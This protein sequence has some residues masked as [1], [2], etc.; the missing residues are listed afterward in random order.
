MTDTVDN[1]PVEP[2][3][4]PTPNNL[5]EA[6]GVAQSATPE[7]FDFVLDKYRKEGRSEQEA[8]LEQAKAYVEAQKRLGGFTGAPESY[9]VKL[10]EALAEMGV[11]IEA[12]DPLVQDAIEFAK[13]N[14]MNQE[15]FSGMLELYAKAEVAKQ[16]AEREYVDNAIKQM[17]HDGMERI[18]SLYQWGQANLDAEALEGFK[19]MAVSPEAIKAMEAMVNKTRNA[20][21]NP[22]AI[23]ASPATMTKAEWEKL[24]FEKDQYGNRRVATDPDFRRKVDDIGK[25]LFGAE[26]HKRIV[27]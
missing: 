26:P 16:Q 12:D 9:E 7:K 24:L 20:P 22:S 23:D 27:G 5:M 15:L 1:T 3:A 2:V 17:G 13:S 18:K 25:R 6:A 19:Q 10:S 11:A 21:V 8:A 14:N 4:E